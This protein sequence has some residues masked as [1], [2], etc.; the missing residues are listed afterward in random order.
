M[1]ATITGVSTAVTTAITGLSTE[2]IAVA[3]TG[4]GI[5]AILLGFRA[6]WRLLK[7]FIR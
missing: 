2:L 3:V 7:G 4:L 1:I 5:A 6:G